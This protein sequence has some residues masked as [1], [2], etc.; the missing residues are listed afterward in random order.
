[1]SAR[2]NPEM[3]VNVAIG[4]GLA[5]VGW[6]GWRMMERRSLTRMLAEHPRREAVALFLGDPATVA[7][8]E[9]RFTNTKTAAQAA[10]EL[11]NALP[12]PTLIET[13][14]H[15][16]VLQQG[17]EFAESIWAAGKSWLGQ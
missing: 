10:I 13:M 1:M 15:E 16:D 17:Q 2:N 12:Q 14:A 9:I 7:A 6:V 11:E 3:P 5:G 4:A 8:A